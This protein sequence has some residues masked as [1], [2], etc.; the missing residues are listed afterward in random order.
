[1]SLFQ[2]WRGSCLSFLSLFFHFFCSSLIYITC[3]GQ[4]SFQL[5]FQ[6]PLSTHPKEI[7][8]TYKAEFRIKIPLVTVL[9][10]QSHNTHI[11][12]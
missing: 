5:L 10:R 1:M 12:T 2:N 9:L 3:L 6:C 7:Q 4:Q 8:S 11:C